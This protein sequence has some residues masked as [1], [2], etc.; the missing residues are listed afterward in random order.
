MKRERGL[1]DLAAVNVDQDDF[2]VPNA[3][4]EI[5]KKNQFLSDGAPPA[6]KPRRESA[7]SRQESKLH[8]SSKP[9]PIAVEQKPQIPEVTEVDAWQ[10][11]CIVLTEKLEKITKEHVKAKTL[12]EENERVTQTTLEEM[13]NLIKKQ[14]ARISKQKKANEELEKESINLTKQIEE[15]ERQIQQM[16]EERDKNA[17]LIAQMH[18]EKSKH[19]EFDKKISEL[20]E[21][22]TLFETFCNLTHIPKADSQNDPFVYLKTQPRH[23]DD[24]VLIFKIGPGDLHDVKYVPICYVKEKDV[25]TDENPVDISKASTLGETVKQLKDNHMKKEQQFE[26]NELPLL[27]KKLIDINSVM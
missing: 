19:A 12:I 20:T 10:Q 11:K 27:L 6:K 4:K 21:Q 9:K 1:T 14:A 5:S 3:P 17:S 22:N 16:S 24:R 26:E 2:P 8:S 23:E 15:K 13:S 25:K 7:P 18:E